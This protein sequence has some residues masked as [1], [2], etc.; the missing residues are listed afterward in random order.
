M[1][2]EALP[3]MLAELEDGRTVDYRSRVYNAMKYISNKDFP[4]DPRAALTTRKSQIAQW[5]RWY[6]DSGA[7]GGP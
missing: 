4:F 1:A 6:E 3:E 2:V 7:S 5:R